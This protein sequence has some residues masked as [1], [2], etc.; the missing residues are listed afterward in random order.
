MGRQ[1]GGGGMRVSLTGA[2]ALCADATLCH[3]P[4]NVHVGHTASAGTCTCGHQQAIS[5]T[6]DCPQ[7][8]FV[9]SLKLSPQTL[10]KHKTAFH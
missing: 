9:L 6:W 8:V 3:V 10:D 1:A 4:F 7:I 5:L 2:G